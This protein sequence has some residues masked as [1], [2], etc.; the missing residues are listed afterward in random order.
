[1]CYVRAHCLQFNELFLFFYRV[2][3]N[4]KKILSKRGSGLLAQ[5]RILTQIFQ[6]IVLF[7]RRMIINTSS[8]RLSQARLFHVMTLWET[9]FYD[10]E[11]GSCLF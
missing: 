9:G 11:F 2:Q 3:I 5:E 4:L 10:S 6:M 8:A 7:I 1:M